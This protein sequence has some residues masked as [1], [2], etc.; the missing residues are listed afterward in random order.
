MSEPEQAVAFE[1]RE[2]VPDLI[3][4]GPA[5][6]AYADLLA[7]G[8][9][10]VAL[11]A[12]R[13]SGYRYG[14]R[15]YLVQLRRAGAG[16]ALIDPLPF[17][18][19]LPVQQATAGVEWIL[20]AAT[21]DL[22][23]LA[24]LGLRPSSLFDTELAGRLLG[25]ER[26]G[27]AALVASELGEVLEKGHGAADWSLR[28]FSPAQLRY[29]ALDVELLVELRDRMHAELVAAGKWAWAEQEFAALV[30][31]QPRERGE[32][33][34]R[35]TSGLHRIRKPRAL[36]IVRALWHAR[37]EAAM[38]SDI[39]PGRILP[40]AAILA[41]AAANPGSAAELGALPEFRGRGQQRRLPAWWRAVEQARALPDSELPG[42]AP[43]TDAPPPPRAWADKNPAAAR[44]LGGAKQVVAEQ[45][46]RTGTPAENLLTPD[47][48]RR[49]CWEPP[50]DQSA[51]SLGAWLQGAGARPWQ[52]ELLSADLA[53][54]FAEAASGGP[55]TAADA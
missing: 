32:E 29:A 55:E 16:T 12:E 47:L 40:D 11:D 44:R 21:Q 14:Q 36:A 54:A 51:A 22:P 45:S 6:Q 9:G 46:A 50:Q 28:P 24:E 30:H 25:R 53:D 26:V 27:L 5:L 33:P 18:D 43:R 2:G 17:A 1:P 49:L 3:V 52:A 4:D 20:H 7:A 19:L 37:D 10:P 48:L 34:W 35:R 13:A 31:F 38:R 15:A 8:S 41:A 23:C 39:A 42:T